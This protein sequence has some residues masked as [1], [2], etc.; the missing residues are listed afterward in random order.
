[1]KNL[2][3]LLAIVVL[4][5]FTVTA[6]ALSMIN[7]NTATEKELESLPGVGQKTAEAIIAKRPLKSIDDLKEIKGISETKFEKIKPLVSLTETSAAA[8]AETA[9]VMTKTNAA[10]GTASSAGRAMWASKKLA[11]DEKISLNSASLEELQ[12]LPGIGAKKAEAIIQARPFKSVEDIMKVKGI[13]AKTFDKMKDH[14][15]L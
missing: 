1:M 5:L 15:T 12:K 10:V 9:P 7:L 14:L 6:N 4:L 13:K 11:V 2:K 3:T 8:Q